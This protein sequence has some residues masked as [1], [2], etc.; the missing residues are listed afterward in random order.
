MI[1]RLVN[2]IISVEGGGH[3]I[4]KSESVGGGHTRGPI[5]IFSFVSDDDRNPKY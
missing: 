5:Y 2:E 4:N 3:R 1:T